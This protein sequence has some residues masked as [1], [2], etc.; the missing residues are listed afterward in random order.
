MLFGTKED[1]QQCR[2]A[3]SLLGVLVELFGMKR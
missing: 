2:P 3:E 1:S